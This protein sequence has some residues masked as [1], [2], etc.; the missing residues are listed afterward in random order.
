MPSATSAQE[1]EPQSSRTFTGMI[2]GSHVTPATPIPLFPWAP[3]VP[4]TCVPWLC[5]SF[6]VASSYAKSQPRTSSTK[7]LAS[8]STPFAGTSSVF[9]QMF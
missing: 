4:A 8:S 7:P 3:T 9:V 5:T 6:G 2:C 1:P